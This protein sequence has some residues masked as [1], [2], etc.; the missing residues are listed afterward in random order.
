MEYQDYLDLAALKRYATAINTRARKLKAKGKIDAVALRSIVLES[1]GRCGWC[2]RDIRDAPFEIE[3]I[4][5][6]SRGGSNSIDN[7]T[8]TCPDC[9]RRKGEQ[10]PAKF[11][12]QLVRDGGVRTALIERVL[13]HFGLESFTQQSMFGESGFGERRTNSE[14]GTSR[15]LSSSDA[16][17]EVPPYRWDN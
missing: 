1:G 14:S 8:C 5:G 2:D 6:L 12:Q 4:V 11:A 16:P 3:H 7:M 13:D 17:P 10:H 15:D 9:N